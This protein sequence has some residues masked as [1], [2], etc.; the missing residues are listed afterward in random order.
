ML[1]ILLSVHTESIISLVASKK[2]SL[3]VLTST[4]QIIKPQLKIKN[5]L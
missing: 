1:N 3:M 5:L 4:S 2:S